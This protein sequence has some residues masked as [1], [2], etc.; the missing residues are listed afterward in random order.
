MKILNKILFTM[1]IFIF[2]INIVSAKE[3][4]M[5]FFYGETCPHCKEEKVLL[6]RLESEYEELTILRYEVWYN[7]ENKNLMNQ[8][9]SEK[10]ITIKGVPLTIVG[11]KY[12]SGYTSSYASRIEDMVKDAIKD[13]NENEV[14]DCEKNE[15]V[16]DLPLIGEVDVKK[17]S[18]GLVAIVIGLVDGFNPCAM[19][20]LLFLISMLIGIKDR[21][22]MWIIGLTFIITSALI[23]L[24]IMMSWLN[25]VVSIVMLA[26]SSL[27]LFISSF[28]LL[29]CSI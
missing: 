19:W 4:T 25:L 26:I 18:I 20:V 1:F 23:Y 9:A 21:K 2:G 5:Y 6:D 17:I 13:V 11:D 14:S 15:N 3:A 16:L 27:F 24:L 8:I 28:V 10:N 29:I 12:I 7:A 22:R